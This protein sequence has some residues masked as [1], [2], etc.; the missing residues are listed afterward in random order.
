MEKSN[1]KN[2]FKRISNLR[3][4]LNT[5]KLTKETQKPVRIL[6]TGAVGNIGYAL[7]FM[8]AQGYMF[9]KNQPVILHLFDIPPMADALRG[10]KMEVFDGAFSLVKG[11]VASTNPEEAFSD[12]DYAIMCGARPRSKGMERKDLLS[13]NGKI[14]EEQ[15]KY[16][17]QYAS[18]DVK[19]LVVGNPANTNAL[20]LIKNAPSIN[21][22]NFTALTRLDHNRA[23][24]QLG[25]KLEEVDLDKIKNVT[26]WGNHSSTQ[27][28]HI[29]Y[30]YLDN[31]IA[32]PLAGLVNDKNYVE[33]DFIKTVQQRGAKIIE[34]RKLSSAASAA[35]AACDHMRDWAL[36]TEEGNWVSMAVYSRGE[37]GSAKDLVFSFPCTCKNGEWSIVSGL[38]LS[39]FSEKK[40]QETSEELKQERKMALGY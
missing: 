5:V 26:I 23:V 18:R 16:F 30:A 19:V 32:L 20:S 27:Y 39:E 25:D 4:Q 40:I 15:G 11:I 28:P 3:D 14:F 36:G 38:K 1:T 9:G 29:D 24:A 2:Y 7:T 12:I 35:S 6:I 37:Y 22:N 34:A 21:P 10:L 8:I 31:D 13:L 17:E 33:G